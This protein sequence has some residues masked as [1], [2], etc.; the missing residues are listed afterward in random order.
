MRNKNVKNT[1][2]CGVFAGVA[3]TIMCFGGLIPIAT[4]VT[5]MLCILIEQMILLGCGR[6]FALTWY[7]AVSILALL[8]GP[9]KEAGLL[10]SFLGNYP[11]L[12]Q[13]FEHS[14][15][16]YLLKILYFNTA[17]G[18]MYCILCRVLGFQEVLNEYIE[19]GAIGLIVFVVL[20]NTTFFILD[21]ILSFTLIKMH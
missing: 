6:R 2:I 18:V 13:L 8:I 10:F 15:I 1:A 21:K 14:K 11:C 16:H 7:V 12:K 17:I 19:L 4:Y 9:D 3:M 5:P 20:G